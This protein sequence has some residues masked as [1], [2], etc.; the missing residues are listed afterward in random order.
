M[1]ILENGLDK[2]GLMRGANAPLKRFVFG[3][4]LT[5]VALY[6]IKPLYFFDSSGKERPWAAISKGDGTVM[7]TN[8]PWWLAAGLAGTFLGVFI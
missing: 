5:S 3:A 7:P 4:A 8:I 2:I 1:D 6:S